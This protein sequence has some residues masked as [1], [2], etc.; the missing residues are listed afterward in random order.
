[1]DLL[2][3]VLTRIFELLLYVPV[4]DYQRRRLALP[5]AHLALMPALAVSHSWRKRAAPLFYRV[6]VVTAGSSADERWQARTNI[7]LILE[8]GYAPKTT[9]LIVLA[10]ASDSPGDPIEKTVAAALSASR[11]TE[12]VWPS[13][14]QLRFYQSPNSVQFGD[15]ADGAGDK[16]IAALNL[17]LAV[18]MPQLTYITALSD[19]RDS[20]GLFILDDLIIAKLPL[21]RSLAVQAQLPLRLGATE[22]PRSLTRLAIHAAL[23]ASTAAVS[24]PYAAAITATLVFLDIGPI[25]PQDIWESFGGGAADFACLR[26]LRLSFCAPP[27][28]TPLLQSI[29]AE[30]EP[31]AESGSRRVH[32]HHHSHHLPSRHHHRHRRRSSRRRSSSSSVS[33]FSADCLAQDTS[34]GAWPLFPCLTT[35]AIDGYP[36]DTAR[37]LENFPRSQLTQLTVRPCATRLFAPLDLAPF[38]SL[39]VFCG[40]AIESAEDWVEHTLQ[41]ALPAMRSL[42]FSAGPS[43]SIEL[44][45]L[46]TTG[47][48][49]LRHLSLNTGLRL[50]EVEKIL[51]CLRQLRL[52]QVTVTEVLGRTH[53]YLSQAARPGKYLQSGSEY[54][55]TSLEDLAV[56]FVGPLEHG[57][58]HRALTGLAN[59]AVKVPSLLRLGTQ[60]ELLAALR[61]LCSHKLPA[62]VQFRE[63]P[64]TASSFLL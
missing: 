9:Q 50:V 35:L 63:A 8:S 36:H 39:A 34:N 37:L 15:M 6:A 4:R 42:S 48:D 23:P 18:S 30:A 12:F 64:A 38:T 5:L 54:L 53:K 13:I 59:L 20:F 22:L 2:P 43:V 19:A 61:A 49:G 40:E 29:D 3:R 46:A 57:H 62:I 24:V 56:V 27:G 7:E 11:F 21:L 25:L 28:R 47:L 14:S 1:M 16:A 55:S 26:H 41:T 32:H 45:A 33:S 52:L 44:P 31:T 10:A 58:L 17:S 51:L 60:R